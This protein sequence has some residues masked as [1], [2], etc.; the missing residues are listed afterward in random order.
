MATLRTRHPTG[1]GGSDL[2]AGKHAGGDSATRR[3]QHNGDAAGVVDSCAW[4]KASNT[5]FY[6]CFVGAFVFG[7][8][9]TQLTMDVGKR[10]DSFEVG[11][12]RA[13]GT[14]SRPSSVVFN[15]GTPVW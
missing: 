12:P 8:A 13:S 3:P 14:G 9:Y 6:L 5:V 10:G 4:R 2:E 11:T 15:L 7:M 1:D